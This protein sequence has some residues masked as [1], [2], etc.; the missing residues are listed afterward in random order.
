MIPA[1][2]RQQQQELDQLLAQ[3]K[4]LR[5]QLVQLDAAETETSSEKST[6]QPQL[7]CC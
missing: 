4:A 2:T 1:P 6:R 7:A 5:E 3:V